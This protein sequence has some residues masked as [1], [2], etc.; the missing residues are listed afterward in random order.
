MAKDPTQTSDE[1][2]E[3]L[4]KEQDE[5]LHPAYKPAERDSILFVRFMGNTASLADVKYEDISPF[6]LIAFGEF[7][8][9]EG[10]AMIEAQKR[11]LAQQ[12]MN[13]PNIAVPTPKIDPSK[14]QG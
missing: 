12:Q 6:Q 9:A 13:K 8:K 2:A 14:L 4:K 10:F 5:M 7:I 3:A 1:M 11:L